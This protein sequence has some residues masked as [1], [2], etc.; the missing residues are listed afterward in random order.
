M[1]DATSA[2]RFDVLHHDEVR[3]LFLTPV[4]D[5]DDVRVVQV[6]GA[7]RLTAE[8]LDEVGVGRELG[9]QHLDRHRTVEQLVAGQEH[10][11]HAAARDAAMQLIPTVEHR[12]LGHGR[13][14]AY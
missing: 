10:V 6:R 12:F 3:A 1:S 9:E 5:R 13:V 4:V 2:A 7:L 14:E 11:G 8:A